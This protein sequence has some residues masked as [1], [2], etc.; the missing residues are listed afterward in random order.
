MY[1]SRLWGAR[2][3]NVETTLSTYLTH[4][5]GFSLFHCSSSTNDLDRDADK[6]C[7]WHELELCHDLAGLCR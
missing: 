6:L 4:L 3:V 2:G 7:D 5:T 1:G